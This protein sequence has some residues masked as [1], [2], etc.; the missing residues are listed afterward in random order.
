[1]NEY[2]CRRWHFNSTFYTAENLLR[3]DFN[4]AALQRAVS[5]FSSYCHTSNI[6]LLHSSSQMCSRLLSKASFTWYNLLSNRLYNAA[7][8]PVQHGCQT[9][10]VWQPVW[11]NSGCSFNTVVKP[12]WQPAVLCIRTFSRLSNR[13]DNRLDVCLHDTAGCQTGYIT[14]LTTGSKTGCIL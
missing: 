5:M 1:M 14:G 3:H 4:V 8:Q 9:G 13:F 11:T 7:W 2:N 12:L 6:G 10:F